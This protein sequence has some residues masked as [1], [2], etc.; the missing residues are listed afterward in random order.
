MRRIGEGEDTSHR[1]ERQY[2]QVSFLT[3]S[4]T[5]KATIRIV[6]TWP[7]NLGF[8]A[9]E[10]PLVG[11]PLAKSIWSRIEICARHPGASNTTRDSHVINL[12]ER[13]LFCALRVAPRR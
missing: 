13:P 3:P 9:C 7:P 5:E 11:I 2:K 10:K 1:V 12:S 4:K 8:C 6:L